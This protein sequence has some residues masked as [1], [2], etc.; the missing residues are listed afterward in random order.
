MSYVIAH[1]TPQ[2]LQTW[3]KTNASS[4]AK[5][6]VGDSWRDYL[7]S[8]SGV[9]KTMYDLETSFLAAQGQTSGT[10]YDRWTA[11]LSAQTG[12]GVHEKLQNKYQ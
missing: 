1:T 12:K 10:M 9:G 4:S 7:A 8:N 5:K 11:Y 3:I 2:N 6:T